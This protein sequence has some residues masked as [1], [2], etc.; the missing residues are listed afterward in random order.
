M[1]A[2]LSP[3]QDPRIKSSSCSV[4]QTPG[5]CL[6]RISYIETC[7]RLLAPPLDL[8]VWLQVHPSTDLGRERLG[9]ALG[10]S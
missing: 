8:F 10:G 3:D 1:G 2:S 5:K 4:C 7:L 6:V 9:L